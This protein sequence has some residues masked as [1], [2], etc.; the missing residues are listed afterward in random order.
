MEKSPVNL[1]FET[2]EH[3]VQTADDNNKDTLEE[4]QY[5]KLLLLLYIFKLVLYFNSTITSNQIIYYLA[6]NREFSADTVWFLQAYF[7][8]SL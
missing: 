7:A 6:I 5:I 1:C 8:G 2:S 4:L 3:N